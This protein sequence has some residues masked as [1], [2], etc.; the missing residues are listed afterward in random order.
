MAIPKYESVNAPSGPQRLVIDPSTAAI[1]PH[2][3]A[4]VLRDVTLDQTAYDSFIDL[5]D[6]LHQNLARQRTLVAIGTHDMDTLK[7][8]FKYTAEPPKQIK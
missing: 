8:P 7:G 6:K 4:A 3:V 1:R 5:Q 2:C